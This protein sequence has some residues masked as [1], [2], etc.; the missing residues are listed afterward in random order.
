[1]KKSKLAKNIKKRIDIQEK[2][3]AIAEGII[4]K[5]IDAGNQPRKKRTIPSKIQRRPRRSIFA[6]SGESKVDTDEYPCFWPKGTVRA[7]LAM[8]MTVGYLI[9]TM[10]CLAFVVWYPA[11]GNLVFEIWKLLTYLE[12]IIIGGYFYT[13]LKMGGIGNGNGGRR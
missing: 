3:L 6:L 10:L 11:I 5:I 13:R 2:K 8:W 1:M 12:A 4:D 9:I 7:I